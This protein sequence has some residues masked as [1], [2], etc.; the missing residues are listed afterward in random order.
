M[1]KPLSFLITQSKWPV[2]R[3][4]AFFILALM[5]RSPEG[6]Q[7]IASLLQQENALASLS[8]TMSGQKSEGSEKV[9]E[10]STGLE[11]LQLEPQQVSPTN[12]AD[13]SAIDREN[14]LVLCTELLKNWNEEFPGKKEVLTDLLEEGTKL[15]IQ[16]K[17]DTGSTGPK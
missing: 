3:S 11:Q 6:A 2:L 14:A 13:T 5:S 9:Q 16:H 17:T 7:V 4:E 15:H 1:T 10:V 8:S 12:Q